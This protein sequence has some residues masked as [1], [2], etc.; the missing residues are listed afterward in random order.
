MDAARHAIKHGLT[1]CECG[2]SRALHGQG[3]AGLCGGADVSANRNWCGCDTYRP[4]PAADVI[5]RQAQRYSAYWFVS[6]DQARERFA[7]FM[8]AESDVCP[9]SHSHPR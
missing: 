8:P 9:G 4:E 1:L 7:R 3:A 5:E 2:H 6:L